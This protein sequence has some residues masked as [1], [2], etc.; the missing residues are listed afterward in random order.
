MVIYK[1]LLRLFN[2]V[3]IFN[4]KGILYTKSVVHRCYDPLI[5]IT[6][7]FYCALNTMP[8]L[9]GVSFS[10]LNLKVSLFTLNNGTDNLIFK[11]SSENGKNHG[12]NN[13]IPAVIL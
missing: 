4:S 11:V 1:I 3:N 12:S 13:I 8:Y 5:I 7:F 10:F 6:N 9:Y 2:L